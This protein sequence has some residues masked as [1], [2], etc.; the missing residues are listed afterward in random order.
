[1]SELSPCGKHQFLFIIIV[2]I[3]QKVLL[4]E[5]L[6]PF[7][8]ASPRIPPANQLLFR[9]LPPPLTTKHSRLPHES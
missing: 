2:I 3:K 8:I 7:R 4:L 9:L 1:M 5:H 6:Q